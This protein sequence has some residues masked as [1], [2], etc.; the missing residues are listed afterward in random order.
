MNGHQFYFKRGHKR[1]RRASNELGLRGSRVQR[2]VKKDEARAAQPCPLA[3]PRMIRT[4]TVTVDGSSVALYSFDGRTWAS[5]PE[6]LSEFEQRAEGESW[7]RGG[8]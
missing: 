2:A 1:Q 7:T 8:Y 6:D 5:R 3:T 4:K